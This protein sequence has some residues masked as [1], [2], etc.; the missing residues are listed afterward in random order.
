MTRLA[1][2]KI[3][4]AFWPFAGL[5]FVLTHWPNLKIEAPI[6]RPDL[7]AHVAVFGVWTAFCIACAF[8]GPALSIRNILLSGVVSVIYSSIDEALQ[9]VPFVQRHAAFDDAAANACGVAL[10]TGIALLFATWKAGTQRSRKNAEGR[11]G[12]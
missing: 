10:I 9:A 12:D 7:I 1:G 3:R 11:G 2:N 5:I 6:Q 4:Y 8:F